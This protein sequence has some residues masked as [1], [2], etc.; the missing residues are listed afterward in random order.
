MGNQST[1]EQQQ[2]Q[3]AMFITEV[4]GNFQAA[5]KAKP[6]WFVSVIRKIFKH[7]TRASWNQNIISHELIFQS[8]KIVTE[9]LP[10]FIWKIA[11]PKMAITI[12]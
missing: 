11:C 5:G 6:N 8:C 10:L 3:L 12:S 7:L 1:K 2:T 9:K 4:R